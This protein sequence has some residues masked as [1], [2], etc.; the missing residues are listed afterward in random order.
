MSSVTSTLLV[1]AALVIVAILSAV[2]ARSLYAY[3][4][5]RRASFSFEPSC[6]R[7]GYCLKGLSGTRCPECGADLI[8][9][10]INRGQPSFR[11]IMT[12]LLAWNLAIV[13]AGAGYSVVSIV[14]NEW[15]QIKPTAWVIDDWSC[16]FGD[17]ST[18]AWREIMRRHRANELTAGDIDE[19]IDAAGCELDTAWTRLPRAHYFLG[20]CMREGRL[21][22]Q[23]TEALTRQAVQVKAYVRPGG[24]A[25]RVSQTNEDAE[26]GESSTAVHS[27]PVEASYSDVDFEPDDALQICVSAFCL[28]PKV[29]FL[30]EV[31]VIAIGG[32]ALDQPMT[33]HV[34]PPPLLAA[35]VCR[36]L[37]PTRRP[38]MNRQAIPTLHS[39][40]A[41]PGSTHSFG[42]DSKGWEPDENE[43]GIPND[44]LALELKIVITGS[45]GL[46]PFKQIAYE[47]WRE[48]VI[49]G[50][51]QRP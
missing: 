2:G 36:A 47:S 46:P 21:N 44:A 20:R 4:R 43:G 39:G 8:K 31:S 38:R 42:H 25:G 22:D 18:D 6:A 11:Q 5:F 12:W 26:E 17:A 33:I 27:R 19:L 50:V 9:K 49:V 13:S 34:G 41:Q 35:E 32:T 14:W 10:N 40:D 30:A 24:V 48:T 16:E 15:D 3:T 45:N 51:R 29:H 28:L 23:Q 7:C 37:P 1:L